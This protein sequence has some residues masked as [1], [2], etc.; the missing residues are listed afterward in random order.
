MSFCSAIYN[1]A[2]DPTVNVT[3]GG[4]FVEIT[5]VSI[6][7]SYE[8]CVMLKQYVTGT[9]TYSTPYTYVDGN[10]GGETY[11]VDSTTYKWER[12][13]GVYQYNL[14]APETWTGTTTG[15][16]I[17]AYDVTVFAMGSN[18]TQFVMPN[19]GG[20]LSSPACAPYNG[21]GTDQTTDMAELARQYFDTPTTPCIDIR[22][23]TEKLSAR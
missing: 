9:S 22:V 11:S 13:D 8:Y 17:S 5:G 2:T 7:V 3:S 4:R 10:H 16:Y 18:F 6:P 14:N 21:M 1:V 23:L 20:S 19:T 12:V 15:V